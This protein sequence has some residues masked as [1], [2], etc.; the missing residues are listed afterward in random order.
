MRWPWPTAAAACRPGMVRGFSAIAEPAPAERDR[1]R[2]DDHHLDAAVAQR[3]GLGGERRDARV[4][5]LGEQAAADLDDDPPGRLQI[6]A[7]LHGLRIRRRRPRAAPA[8]AAP[9][10]RRRR[11]RA[12]PRRPV[13][14]PASSVSTFSTSS[15]RVTRPAS[16]REV[17]ERALERVL[18]RLAARVADRLVHRARAASAPWRRRGRARRDGARSSDRRGCRSGRSASPRRRGAPP[19]ARPRRGARPSC[20]PPSSTAPSPAACSTREPVGVASSVTAL[21]STS[22]RRSS[23]S[24]RTRPARTW[25]ASRS[26]R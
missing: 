5:L 3:L 17:R 18:E 13:A 15:R 8:C 22:T 25:L 16:L 7:R 23:A 10:P 20:A 24:R 11:R 12:R 6:R 21:A 1:A 2:G 26:S 9:T 4:G 14:G 19:A